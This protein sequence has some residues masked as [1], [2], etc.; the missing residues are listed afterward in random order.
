MNDSVNRY[1][2]GIEWFDKI[3]IIAGWA[4][5]ANSYKTVYDTPN[6]LLG[7]WLECNSIIHACLKMLTTA[8]S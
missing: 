1:A 7:H 2:A 5:E 3:W 8:N 4:R 6:S